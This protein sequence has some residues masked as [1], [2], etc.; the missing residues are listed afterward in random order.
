VSADV[1]ILRL[2]LGLARCADATEF[3]VNVGHVGALAQALATLAPQDR[4]AVRR[5]IDRKDAAGLAAAAPGV[6]A[7]LPFIIGRREALDRAAQLVGDVAHPNEGVTRLHAVDAALT[8]DEPRP[9]VYDF[10]EVRGLEPA[11][12]LFRTIGIA[13]S[14]PANTRK[15][16]VPSSDGT[17]SFLFVKPG[18]VPVYVES[19]A[20]DLGIT[21]TDVLRE[22]DADVLEPLALGFGACRL[23]VATPKN[24]A[25]PSLPGGVT[26][27]VATEY[28]RLTRSFFAET[29]LGVEVI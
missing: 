26:P 13:A 11:I 1:E 9:G 4:A 27:R 16:L 8:D 5:L 15:L 28:P 12:A 17:L 18:D 14:E 24:V 29:G 6:L 7:E 20:A 23:V 22:T 21:G 3:Q 19:G 10:G 2:A 25:Y